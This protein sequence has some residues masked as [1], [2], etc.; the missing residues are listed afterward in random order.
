[1]P[2]AADFE[3]E[4]EELKSILTSGVF[5]R[6]PNLAHLLTYVCS[7]YFEGK[8]EQIKEYNVAVEALGRST[9]FDQK[10]D[11]IVRVEANRLRKRLREYYENEGSGH[12]VRIVIPLGQ[13]VPRFVLR[14]SMEATTNV[15]PAVESIEVAP[16]ADLARESV[17]V[18]WRQWMI[19]AVLVASAILVILWVSGIGRK[20]GAP[21]RNVAAVVQEGWKT[22]AFWR[23]SRAG[24]SRMARVTSG[25]PTAIIMAALLRVA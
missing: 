7:Q 8:A 17:G 23:A 18:R 16:A 21:G 19:L 1:M 2:T 20:K 12:P 4:K 6:A 22:F 5:N 11:S 3:R 10:K 24:I 13:Y 14:D 9:N 25:R 15:E